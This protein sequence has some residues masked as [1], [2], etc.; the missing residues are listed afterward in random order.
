MAHIST[1]LDRRHVD[2]VQL[3]RVRSRNPSLL[4]GAITDGRVIVDRPQSWQRLKRSRAA[5]VRAA[6]DLDDVRAAEAGTA[7]AELLR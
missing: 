6:R 2:P 5:V 3:E 1:G 4:A 7:L